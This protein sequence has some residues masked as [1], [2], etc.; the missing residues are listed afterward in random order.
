MAY[1]SIELIVIAVI[2]LLGAAGGIPQIFRWIKP[3]PHLKITEGTISRL[4]NDNYKYQIKLEVE[5]QSKLLQRNGDAS[6]VT[7]DFFV[8]DKNGVQSGATTNLLIS[9]YLCAGTKIPKEFEAY[10]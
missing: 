5:N 2:A 8:V 4:P 1:D 10:L 7:A 6:N 3:K 9:S